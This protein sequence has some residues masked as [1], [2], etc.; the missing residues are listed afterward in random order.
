L[1]AF[2][3]FVVFA[4]VIASA[5]LFPFPLTGLAGVAGVEG[6]DPS[7]GFEAGAA[8]FGFLAVGLPAVLAATP[9]LLLAGMLTG[10]LPVVMASPNVLLG[11]LLFFYLAFLSVLT[12]LSALVDLSPRCCE[13]GLLSSLVDS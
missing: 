1:A 4:A 11:F 2:S 13:Q 6:L 8:A 12:D 7:V 10:L 5:S 3:G 9:D